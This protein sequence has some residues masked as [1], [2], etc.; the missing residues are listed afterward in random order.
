VEIPN[1]SSSSYA[2]YKAVYDAALTTQKQQV[3]AAEATVRAA[4]QSLAQT[5]A[6]LAYKQAPARP[7]DIQSAE[8]AVDSARASLIR[9]QADL[10]DRTI[11]APVAGVIT[12]VNYEVGETTSMSVPVVVLLAEGNHEIKVQVPEADIAKLKEG[13][14]TDITLDAFGS[15]DHFSGHISFIDPA[16]NQIQD[17]VYYKVT[18]LFD[19]NDERIKPGMTANVD[20]AAASRQQVLVVPLRAI[21]Y[22]SGKAYSEVLVGTEPQRRQVEIGLKGDDGLVEVTSGVSEGDLIVVSKTNG[23]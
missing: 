8:A 7:Y 23:K 14:L 1:T 12:Q 4:E 16:S 2:T 5:Q 19:A 21:K 15:I 13:Q 6:Q 22:E 3:D 11:T 18:V 10:V 9:A 17:V 20:V